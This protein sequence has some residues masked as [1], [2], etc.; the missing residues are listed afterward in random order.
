M[1]LATPCDLRA[2]SKGEGIELGSF[3]HAALQPKLSAQLVVLLDRE[4]FLHWLLAQFRR[5]SRWPS[6]GSP[7]D[8]RA[9]TTDFRGRVQFC[10]DPNK[11]VGFLRSVESISD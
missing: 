8:F 4:E 1:C 7:A 10:E 5:L 9:Y 6:V 3:A 11:W 2:R